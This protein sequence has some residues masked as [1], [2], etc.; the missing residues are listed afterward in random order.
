MSGGAD[1][2][3]TLKDLLSFQGKFKILHMTWIAFFLCFVAWFNMAPLATTIMKDLG[4][5]KTDLGILAIAN[6]AMTIP[7]RIIVGQLLDKYGPRRCYSWLL[8]TMSVPIFGFAL[9]KTFT[10]LF[11]WRLILG[12]VGA[13][14]VIGIRMVSEWFPPREVGRAEGLYAGWGNFGSAAAA[15]VLPLVALNVF[16]GAYGW[17]YAIALT[18]VLCLV[19]GIIYYFSVT[20]CPP[21]KQYL[22]PEKTG[23]MEVS[24]WPALWGLIIST[25]PLVGALDL[26]AWR[27]VRFGMIGWS[28]FT[29]ITVILALVFLYQAWKI[30]QVN[31]PRLRR[32]IP[33]NDQY[34]FMQVVC[35]NLTYVSNFG[36]ELAVVSM[37]PAWFEKTF[38]LSPQWAGVIASSFAFTNLFARP[39]GGFLSDKL[40]SRRMVM[41]VTMLGIATG[42]FGMAAM[43]STTPLLIAVVVTFYAGCFIQAAE[44]ATFAIVPL[45]KKRITGQVA[46]M[47]G[48]YGNVGAVF[49]L[50]LLT[51]V[52]HQ[53][54]F[55]SIAIAATITLIVCYLFLKEPE[56]SFAAEYAEH[57][58]PRY[59]AVSR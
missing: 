43:R 34:S 19:W 47:A 58:E 48:A 30:W 20:D 46:G 7:A 23:A 8:I 52:T 28:A 18:G 21:G 10:G 15:M 13:S 44:G 9:S 25:L 45:V 3:A 57:D 6:V 42:F 49:F 22:R 31:A 50:T 37:L 2:E 36:A 39:L 59:C 27:L 35:L 14:F 24:S 41:L 11:F 5:T 53:S 51:L 4:L 26:L 40:G 56:G 16:G 17:R 33:K 29:W 55:L 32:G 1:R 54:F 38:G 12:C